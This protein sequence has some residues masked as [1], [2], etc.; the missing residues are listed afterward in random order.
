LRASLYLKGI[1]SSKK[2]A[3][4]TYPLCKNIPTH[5]TVFSL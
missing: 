3:F 4:I 2:P 1:T 5:F